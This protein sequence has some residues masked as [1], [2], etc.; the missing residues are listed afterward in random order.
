MC[1]ANRD[2]PIANGQ[3]RIPVPD[4]HHRGTGAGAGDHSSQHSLLQ[5]GVEV[6]G[7]FVEQ[8]QPCGRPEGPGETEPL[9]L[10]QGQADAG[11]ADPGVETVGQ[12]AENLVESGVAAGLLQIIQW[13]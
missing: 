4:H 9:S 7:G 8:K 13:P 12:I 2:H 1:S 6:G 10:P 5:R 3:D 11:T